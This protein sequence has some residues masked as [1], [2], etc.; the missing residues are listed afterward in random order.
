MHA[1]LMAAVIALTAIGATLA[2]TGIDPRVV[3]WLAG[4]TFAM[5][6]ADRLVAGIRVTRMFG[7][8]AGLLF[9]P[10][11]L[12]RDLAWVAAIVIWSSRRLR[13]H[14]PRPWHS[15]QP[16]P[17]TPPTAGSRQ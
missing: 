2:M 14:G 16:R 3:L 7:D 17:A 4:V 12:A 5:L 15:M 10:I 13:G 9:V 6:A 1:P 11:H 8:P